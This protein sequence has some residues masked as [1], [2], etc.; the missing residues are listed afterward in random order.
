MEITHDGTPRISIARLL[1]LGI[2]ISWEDAI[3]ITQAVILESDT[4]SLMSGE[5]TLVRPDTCFLTIAGDVSTPHTD[6]AAPPDGT[7]EL[8]RQLL[9]SC[10]APPEVSRMAA[11]TDSAAV[12]A[13]LVHISI[14]DPA[15]RVAAVARAALARQAAAVP[16]PSVSMLTARR[17]RTAEAV[18][19]GV[20]EPPATAAP[21]AV[22]PTEAPAPRI[23]A[24][25]AVMRAAPPLRLVVPPEEPAASAAPEA[26]ELYQLRQ[27]LSPPR[28]ARW[29]FP[30]WQYAVPVA[31]ALGVAAV[32][33]LWVRTG[34]DEPRPLVVVTNPHPAGIIGFAPA[35]RP[36]GPGSPDKVN[37][38][39]VSREG[40]GDA[41][42]EPTDVS[43]LDLQGLMVWPRPSGEQPSREDESTAAVGRTAVPPSPAEFSAPAS[44]P[45]SAVRAA[46]EELARVFS[47]ADPD[48]MP[49]AFPPRQRASGV[50]EPGTPVPPGWPYLLVVV[51]EQGVVESVRLFTPPMRPGESLYRQ[52]MLVSAAKAWRFIPAVRNGRPVRYALRLPLEP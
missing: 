40:Q 4:A 17:S 1:A 42:P 35:V 20:P 3:A 33:A 19:P 51:D 46:A 31:A 24:A 49:P 48:V 37:R 29:A 13:W 45:A 39:V 23:A 26:A 30:W 14:A 52:R 18:A 7:V 15:E 16:L 22:S 44:E 34:H 25:A 11:S 2:P 50:H 32:A 6:P 41:G 43:P 47:A 8:L 21:P 27:R 38:P 28:P 36:E 10:E 12:I 5:P 9:V